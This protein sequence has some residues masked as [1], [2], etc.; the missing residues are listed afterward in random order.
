M[1][2]ASDE[3]GQ[4]K[5][6]S[7][8]RAKLLL[9]LCEFMRLLRMIVQPQATPTAIETF[10]KDPYAFPSTVFFTACT[11]APFAP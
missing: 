2:W 1:K 3:V 6:V 9:S 7:S 8:V 11:I 10:P 4:G 5:K